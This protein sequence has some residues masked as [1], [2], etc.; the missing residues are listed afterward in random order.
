MTR[1]QET[2]RAAAMGAT[3]RLLVSMTTVVIECP[4]GQDQDK[5]ALGVAVTIVT[6]LVHVVVGVTQ[7]LIARV[8]VVAALVTRVQARPCLE[9]PSPTPLCCCKDASKTKTCRCR[10]SARMC[11]T[12]GGTSAAST[13]LRFVLS[14]FVS[15]RVV[16]C[17]V[18]SFRLLFCWTRNCRFCVSSHFLFEGESL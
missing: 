13:S 15:C 8:V 10:A 9:A 5:A 12:C 11:R 14:R 2:H 1:Q 7:V 4:Q 18:V 3:L 17:R 6:A 16:L